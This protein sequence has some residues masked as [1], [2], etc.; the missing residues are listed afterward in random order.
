ME[1]LREA[2]VLVRFDL[3]DAAH[4]FLDEVAPLVLLHGCRSADGS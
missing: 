3:A 1:H 4:D 2:E